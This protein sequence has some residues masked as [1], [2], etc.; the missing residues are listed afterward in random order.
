MTEVE[1]TGQAAFPYVNNLH[2]REQ[3]QRRMKITPTPPSPIEGEGYREGAF[4]TFYEFI[5]HEQKA[6]LQLVPL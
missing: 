6:D 1:I 3:A 4:S 5:I 2:A